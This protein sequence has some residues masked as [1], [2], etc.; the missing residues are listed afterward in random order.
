MIT[1]HQACSK[2]KKEKE[3]ESNVRAGQQ[4][5]PNSNVEGF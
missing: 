3:K 1:L 2:E 5:A 4:K